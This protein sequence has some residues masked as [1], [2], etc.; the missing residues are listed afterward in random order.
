MT[1]DASVTTVRPVLLDP[2]ADDAADDAAVGTT[3]RGLTRLAI[4]ATRAGA[5]FER[6]GLDVDPAAWL[7]APRS[8]FGGK[9]ALSACLSEARLRAGDRTARVR[10]RARS[11][12]GSDGP[13]RSDRGRRGDRGGG[14]DSGWG[15]R[16]D[17]VLDEVLHPEGERLRTQRTWGGVREGHSLRA[18]H[19]EQG[20]RDLR[21]ARVTPPDLAETRQDDQRADRV[22]LVLLPRHASG[23]EPARVAR[24]VPSLGHDALDKE[25]I[26]RAA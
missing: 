7:Q 15:S 25:E 11:R 24:M 8:V 20:V 6:E 10:R 23:E 21:I 1:L 5:A 13:R 3:S 26:E 16:F 18:E 14:R 4:V 9:S 12:R 19:E 17:P 2:F 22:G